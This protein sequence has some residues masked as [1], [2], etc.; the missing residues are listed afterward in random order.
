[1]QKEKEKTLEVRATEILARM[2]R[3]VAVALVTLIGSYGVYLAYSSYELSQERSAQEELFSLQKKVEAKTDELLKAELE[4]DT[5]KSDKKSKKTQAEKDRLDKKTPEYLAQHYKNLLAEYE[6]FIQKNHGRKAA[7]MAAVQVADLAIS[8]EDLGL[9]QKHL[10]SVLGQPK[11]KD[12]FY[13]LIRSQLGTVL[14]DLK[15]YN[16]AADLFGQIVQNKKQEYFHPHALLRLGACHLENGHYDKAQ[17]T[18]A[19]L[20]K[21]FPNTSAA[22]RAKTLKRLAMIKKGQSS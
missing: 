10:S 9:A 7:Y 19:M 4:T 20:E 2:W 5:N 8:H 11:P 13:G 16:E 22:T 18:F 6:A 15:K 3:P 17:A 14:M 12:L 1:M 21:D